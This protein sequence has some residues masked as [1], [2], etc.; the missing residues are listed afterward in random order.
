MIYFTLTTSFGS[1]IGADDFLNYFTVCLTHILFVKIFHEIFSPW[2]DEETWLGKH[3]PGT[4]P[5][6]V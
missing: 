5:D 6:H 1:V 4:F 3:F 2:A